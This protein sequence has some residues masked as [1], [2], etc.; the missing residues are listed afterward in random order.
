MENFGY[1]FIFG[2]LSV[3]AGLTYAVFMLLYK[4]NKSGMVV[5]KRMRDLRDEL[6]YHQDILY[7]KHGAFGKVHGEDAAH[8]I[9]GARE[10]LLQWAMEL[11]G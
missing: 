8:C 1:F 6:G 5:A 3:V 10:L 4:S 9:A 2:L 7:G 11:E